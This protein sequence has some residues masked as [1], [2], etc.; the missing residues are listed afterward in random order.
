MIAALLLTTWI[1]TWACAPS[2][3]DGA[4]SFTNVTL[5]EIARV[6]IGGTAAR[7]RF[8]NRF[9]TA[10]L[11]L[12]DATIALSRDGSPAVIPGTLRTLAFSGARSVTVPAGSDVLSDPVELDVG[13][14]STVLVSI[15]VPGPTG[16]ATYHHLSYR[17]VYE[18]AGDRAGQT[19]AGGFAATG[20]NWYFLG[21]I[22]VSGTRAAGAIVAL[23]TRSRTARVRRSTATIAGPTISRN[24]CYRFR[25]RSA[26][27]CSTRPSTATV[28]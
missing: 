11:V 21:G 15:Y 3:A 5:R 6:S 20:T 28:S 24:G 27:A 22:D 8:T 10:P 13:P 4:R 1:G 14:R 17:H 12:G 18:A 16:P 2:S 9:G 19:G 26:S 23:A 7:V 25:P